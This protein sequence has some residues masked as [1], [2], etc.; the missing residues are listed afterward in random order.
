MNAGI[1]TRAVRGVRPHS[2][3]YRDLGL[4]PTTDTSSVGG[5]DGGTPS[6]V[7]AALWR[8]NDAGGSDPP[9]PPFYTL[10]D[11]IERSPEANTNLSFH[12]TPQFADRNASSG[13]SRTVLLSPNGGGG[14]SLHGGEKHDLQGLS[15]SGQEPPLSEA[16]S[17][18]S[19]RR[20]TRSGGG[21]EAVDRD[22]T[23]TPMSGV[24]QQQQSGG[25][26][27]TL[28]LPGE[29][30]RP[31]GFGGSAKDDSAEGEGW[32]TVFG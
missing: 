16:N 4:L 17:W 11:R 14:G 23:T 31:E 18:W 25:G 12:L 21:V 5:V 7:T 15:T 13:G 2:L 3:F 10:E 29:I 28:S 24:I 6:Q 26:L 32:V 9:P 30:V 22:G 8:A 20:E 1:H 27:L 19:P